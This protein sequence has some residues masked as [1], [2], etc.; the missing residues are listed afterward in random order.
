MGLLSTPHLSRVQRRAVELVMMLEAKE[1][2]RDRTEAFKQALLSH[3]PQRYLPRLYPELV[4]V[5]ETEEVGAGSGGPVE[6]QFT[7]KVD[8]REAEQVL[9][10]LLRKGRV[11][12]DMADVEQYEQD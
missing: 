2:G 9:N 11:S 8:Q 5:S 4:P 3:D 6:Y 12:M 10:D 1:K 7:E